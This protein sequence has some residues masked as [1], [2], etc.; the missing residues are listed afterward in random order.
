MTDD[1]S[2]S[3]RLCRSLPWLSMALIAV[4]SKPL[5]GEE[6][7]ADTII[8]WLA[9]EP[10]DVS[11]LDR[12]L[13]RVLK[14]PAI[15]PEDRQRLGRQMVAVMIRRRIA[16]E[17]LR[18]T[19]QSASQQ[20]IDLRVEQ[21][22]GHLSRSGRLMEQ[23]LKQ[24]QQTA[25]DLR[26]RIAW[27]LSWQ[28]FVRKHVTD[29]NLKK[30]YES[31]RRE[32]DGTKLRVSHILLPVEEGK[33][34]TAL[35][36]ARRIGEQIARGE[37]TFEKAAKQHSSAPSADSGGDIGWISR[38]EPMTESFSKAAFAL[39]IGQVSA[40]V[41]SPFG[42]HLIQCTEISPGRREWKEVKGE[43][44]E[45]A[46]RFLFDWVVEQQRPRVELKFTEEGS[47]WIPSPAPD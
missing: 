38:Q 9:G 10:I 13:R 4:L 32:F 18:R 17:Y 8:C 33:V 2:G 7:P 6:I 22:R 28:R 46:T 23:Y 40:P 42:L 26:Q 44:S 12:E 29:E 21:I 24:T 1:S 30:H 20:D 31:H 34:E 27:D 16:L 47:L 37:L 39:E 15:T 14:K 5:D 19:G 11:D 45:A 36:E 35:Q 43:L 41:R 3:Y 25:S